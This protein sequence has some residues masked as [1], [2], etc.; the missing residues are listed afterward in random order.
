MEQAFPGQPPAVVLRSRYTL[1]RAL[2]GIALVAVVALS[3]AVV[4]VAGDG[5]EVSGTSSAH[6]IHSID[7]GGFNPNTGR[8][9]SAPLPRGG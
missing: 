7:S 1:V 4:V 3:A 6:P 5:N 9:D 8:P 2:L